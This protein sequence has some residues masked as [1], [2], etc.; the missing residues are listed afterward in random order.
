MTCFQVG[1]RLHRRPRP[2][3]AAA[4]AIRSAS[5]ARRRAGC[6]ARP[7]RHR[8]RRRPPRRDDEDLLV[9][10][11][12]TRPAPHPREPRAGP[13]SNGVREAVRRRAARRRG[14]PSQRVEH[15]AASVAEPVGDRRRRS[16]RGSRRPSRRRRGRGAS[17]SPSRRPPGRRAAG[18]VAR[19]AGHGLDERRRDDERQVA[20]RRRRPRRARRPPCGPGARRRPSRAPSTRASA[21]ASGGLGRGR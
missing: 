9:G 6:R 17:C 21:S 18:P 11:R 3:R 7:S 1:S 13:S 20:D 19:R 8:A 12:V 16:S 10:H 14:R 15:G 4:P 2:E 5:H